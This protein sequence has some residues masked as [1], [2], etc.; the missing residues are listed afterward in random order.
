MRAAQFSAFGGPEALSVV[1]VAQPVPGAGEVLIGVRAAALQP[2]DWKA[3]AG[4]IPLPPG[5]SLPLITGNEFAGVIADLGPDVTGWSVGEAVAG[6]RTFGAAAEYVVAPAFDIARK[7]D[8]VSFA[9]AATF[10]ATAQTADAAIEILPLGPAAVLLIFGAAGGVGAFA[11]Q[12][13]L[14]TGASVVGVAG[15]AHA[16]YL[17]ELGAIPV[18]SGPGFADRIAAAAPSP[19]T[20]VLDTVGGEALD[21]A[22]T[23]GI[24]RAGI[25]SIGDSR[26]RELGVRWPQGKRDGARLQ[27]LLDLAAAGQLRTLVRATFPLDDIAAAHRALE[28]GHG[29]GKIVVTV[30]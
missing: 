23:L 12:L 4:R 22:L 16:D 3:R 19:V 5:S 15:A 21:Y 26:W 8:N 24:D 17:R 29:R 7:P 9:E 27:K 10:G 2:F 13:A 20:A 30:G 11:A 18:A 14:N 28:T 6:R 1:D 25:V